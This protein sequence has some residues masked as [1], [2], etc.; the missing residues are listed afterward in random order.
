L[1]AP[2]S[3]GLN[4][5]T[6]APAAGR[7]SGVHAL[8]FGWFS[9]GI[10]SWF[11][12]WGLQVVLFSWLLVGELQASAEWVGLAQTSLMLPALFLLLV[13]GLVADRFDPRRMLVALHLAAGLP[14]LALVLV[15]VSGHLSLSA[16]FLYGVSMGA[17]SAFIMPAR[18]TLLSRVAG[19]D[20]MRAV[21]AM[22]A[23]QFGAQ[24]SGTLLAGAARW[25]GSV[26]MLLLQSALLVAGAAVTARIPVPPGVEAGTASRSALR[27]IV[28]GLTQVVRH[29]VLRAQI[30]L[31]VAVGM[32]F[33]GPFTVLFPLLV[34]DY[35]HG[36]V[37]QL[38]LV[39]MLFPVGTIVGS[40]AL[41]A[42]GGLRRK[43]L[44]AMLALVLGAC[45]LISIGFGL[46]FPVMVAVTLAWGLCG[47]VFINC[48]R[49]LYQEAAP[50]AQRARVLSVYQL[51]FMGAAPVGTV[52][53][54]LVG[55]SLGTL[56]TLRLFGTCMLV[57]VFLAAVLTNTARME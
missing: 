57:V 31:V 20:M 37:A 38:S 45:A 33:V 17:L 42:R 6:A 41:R 44:A 29:S 8:G 51:G 53:S 40:L 54:G 1:A 48:T 52:L 26:P 21:T 9:A 43:G 55:A 49:T 56:P 46:P 25:V 18:D 30:M 47:S 2:E 12:A 10:A 15:L 23:V 32:L 4:P 24:A 7:P 13:G 50:L 34:R 11:G 36:G 19:P 14:A 35:Y 16:L 3:S 27:D 28:E 39:L 22:T 5:A